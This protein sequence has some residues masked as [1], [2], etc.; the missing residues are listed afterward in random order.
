[1]R[2]CVFG[3]RGRW[4]LGSALV[5]F[6]LAAAGPAQAGPELRLQQGPVRYALEGTG[7]MDEVR[8]VARNEARHPAVVMFRAGEVL[9]CSDAKYGRA[10]VAD[11]REIVI[12]ASGNADVTINVYVVGGEAEA[13]P[14]GVGFTHPWEVRHDLREVILGAR[15]RGKGREETSGELRIALNASPGEREQHIMR[16]FWDV[17]RGY[18]EG[19]P[20]LIMRHVSP[21]GI[22][23]HQPYA[24]PMVLTREEF[25]ARTLRYM[26]TS[27][28]NFGFVGFDGVRAGFPTALAHRYTADFAARN[29][30]FV[31]EEFKLQY[32]EDR[33]YLRYMVLRRLEVRPW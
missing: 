28:V 25:E 12:A 17:E 19:R 22:I 24:P 18:R 27:V 10:V 23:V 2:G 16:I 20:E 21:E 15:E 31:I 1:M 6:A 3:E 30:Q 14:R 32:Y 13:P 11:D 33:W 29:N 7:A 4:L 5:A 9:G 8:V 26:M